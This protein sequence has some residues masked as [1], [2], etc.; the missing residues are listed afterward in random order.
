MGTLL[1][2][3]LMVK[4]SCVSMMS[5]V[6]GCYYP[7]NLLVLLLLYRR[8][9][10]KQTLFNQILDSFPCTCWLECPRLRQAPRSYPAPRSPHLHFRC[11][12]T[13]P[14]PTFNLQIYRS[15]IKCYAG[16]SNTE[17]RQIYIYN[18]QVLYIS[19]FIF[20][21]PFNETGD[22]DTPSN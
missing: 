13:N 9:Q 5:K 1:R 15:R 16:S 7:R 18:V 21:R 12:V 19:I 17:K 4:I 14:E 8:Y 3:I 11:S 6:P 2:K 20:Y 22:S 10:S